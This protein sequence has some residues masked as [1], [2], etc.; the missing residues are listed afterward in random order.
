VWRSPSPFAG[1]ARTCR[2]RA[3]ACV[4]SHA[5]SRVVRAGRV[6]CFCVSSACY[7]A[8]VRVS[9]AHCHVVLGI[10]NSSRLESLVLIILVIYL[11]AASVAD[12]I[13]TT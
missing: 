10:V 11:T 3:V 12:L 2:W 4:V 7:A 5:D 6:Y 1:V 8:R 13:K 9:F